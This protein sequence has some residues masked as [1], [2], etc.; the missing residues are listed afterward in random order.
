MTTTLTATET[1]AVE[2]HAKGETLKG[3]QKAAF[4]RA[5]KK[6]AEM[7]ARL[8]EQQAKD[9]A[10]AQA[11]E[12][13]NEDDPSGIDAETAEQDDADFVDAETERAEANVEKAAEPETDGDDAAEAEAEPQANVPVAGITRHGNQKEYHLVIRD[14]GTVK[15]V[16]GAAGPVGVSR[17]SEVKGRSLHSVCAKLGATKP[18]LRESDIDWTSP[19]RRPVASAPQAKVT[20]AP[21]QPK[22][23][24]IKAQVEKATK[25]AKPAKPAPKAAPAKKAAPAPKTTKAATSER[26]RPA[27]VAG[28][29][30]FLPKARGGVE[31]GFAIGDHK[32]VVLICVEHG[33]VKLV[34]NMGEARSDRRNITKVCGDSSHKH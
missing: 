30:T 2:A 11:V 19:D 27:A 32:T 18:F 13:M 3:A 9:A 34:R 24:Q 16:C 10:K 31:I 29:E 26:F 17:P 20:E 6:I 33:T 21:A 28:Y 7:D 22:A 8:A 15:T 5:Q 23:Q 4:D 14:G 25:A 1:A 12:T